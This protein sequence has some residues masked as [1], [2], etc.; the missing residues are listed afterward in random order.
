MTELTAAELVEATL[1]DGAVHWLVPPT[2]TVALFQ[3]WTGLCGKDIAGRHSSTGSLQETTCGACLV[4]LHSWEADIRPS[5][6]MRIR[7][8]LRAPTGGP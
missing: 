3:D 5:V 7:R 8:L 2:Y 4:R 6:A 1:L